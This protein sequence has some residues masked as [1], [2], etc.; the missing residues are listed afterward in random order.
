MFKAATVVGKEPFSRALG[1]RMG[2]EL[3]NELRRKPDA[4]WLFCA[5]GNGIEDLVAGAFDVT[6]TENF[7]GCTTDGEISSAGYSAASAVLAGIATDQISFVVSSVS[8]IRGDGNFA[9]KQLARALPPTSRHVQLLSDGLTGNGSAIAN[10]MTS[11]LGAQIPISGGAAGDARQFKQTWQFIRNKVLSDSAVA[12][13]MAGNFKVGTGVRSGWF[14]AGIP[15]KV[16][17]AQGNVVYEFDGEPA[18]T[19]Y[20]KYLGPLASKLP[21]VGV[22]F[23]FGMV[24]ESLRL[25]EDAILRAPMGLNEQDGSVTFA[26]EVPEGVTMTLATGGLDENLL[27]ASSEAARRAMADLGN[28]TTPAMIFFY[29][30]MARKILLG[31]R[32]GE[33]TSRICSVVGRG[34]PVTGF[35]TYG[36]YCPS[37]RDSGC[38]LHNE[39]ATVTVIGL[40]S[41]AI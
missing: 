25:G 28:D 9:G 21:A 18:L 8:N 37:R 39:T 5:P 10:G 40:P 16:T 12:M 4:C 38:Q 24:D 22:Q 35:Y 34:V 14:P 32:T 3:V 17:R 30:C 19:V 20:R 31:H 23:P 27:E 15:R 11:V 29:S 2:N 1:Q 13:G 41:S 7:I 33:E 36:E 26:G 6:G